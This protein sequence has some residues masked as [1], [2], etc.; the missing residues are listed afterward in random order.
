MCAKSF[1]VSQSDNAPNCPIRCLKD[2]KNDDGAIVLQERYEYTGMPKSCSCPICS[3]TCSFAFNVDDVAKIMAAKTSQGL[4]MHDA[5][6]PG[7]NY[8][9]STSTNLGNIFSSAMSSGI[10]AVITDPVMSA[11]VT[12]S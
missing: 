6:L 4:E 11:L 3:C 8:D 7:I 5:A 10:Q 2:L 9:T 1:C 12:P